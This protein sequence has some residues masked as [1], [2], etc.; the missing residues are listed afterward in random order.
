MKCCGVDG[1]H[2]YLND[3]W[4]RKHP[5]PASCCVRSAGPPARPENES[6]CQKDASLRLL[7]SVFLH[8]RGCH[9]S[10]TAWLSRRITLLTALL[11]LVICLQALAV[12]VLSWRGYTRNSTARESGQSRISRED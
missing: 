8:T 6:Q 9:R 3:A 10:L 7:D 12:L 5:V 11:F 2:D 4:D 1:Y